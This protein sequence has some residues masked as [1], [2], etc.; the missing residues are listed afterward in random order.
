[1]P[2]Y[3][4]YTYQSQIIQLYE[5]IFLKERL[6]VADLVKI[7]GNIFWA[8]EGKRLGVSKNTKDE[9]NLADDII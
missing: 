4:T 8:G 7:V 9:I 5:K 6:N 3:A 1:M 2:I